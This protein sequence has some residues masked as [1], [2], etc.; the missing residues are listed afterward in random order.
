MIE[1]RETLKVVLEVIGNPASLSII[2]AQLLFNMKEAGEKGLNA[3]TS[4]NSKTVSDIDF[5]ASRAS[6]GQPEHFSESTQKSSKL[7]WKNTDFLE[8]G[9]LVSFAI[10]PFVLGA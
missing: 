8:F 7:S 10:N 9:P 3:G 4:C 6:T 1:H 2:G 5:A